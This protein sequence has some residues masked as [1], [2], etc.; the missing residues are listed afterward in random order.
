MEEKKYDIRAI[1]G[2][3]NP[4]NKFDGTRHN[5]GFAVLDALSQRSSGTWRQKDNY[6]YTEIQLHEKKIL[7]VKPQTFMNLSGQVMPHLAKRGIEVESVIV[8]HD[9]LEVKFG[10]VSFKESGSHRGHNGLRSII[11]FIGSDFLRVRC[12]IGRPERK[13]DVGSYVLQ[14]FSENEADVEKMI[15][16]AIDLIE[17]FV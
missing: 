3:G 12:G 14:K 16:D 7:L 4:G 1:I 6:E 10:K 11:S 17:R 13:E 8:I 2:L 9:E 15:Y 5:I